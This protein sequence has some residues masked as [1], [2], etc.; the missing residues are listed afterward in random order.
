[1]Q[2]QP[3]VPFF[4]FFFFVQAILSS[5]FFIAEREREI[6]LEEAR[7]EVDSSLDE[8]SATM[9]H[10]LSV[11]IRGPTHPKSDIKDIRGQSRYRAR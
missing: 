5:P 8:E 2:S 11:K 3:F 4:F 6:K 7:R 10:F 9:E 1:M